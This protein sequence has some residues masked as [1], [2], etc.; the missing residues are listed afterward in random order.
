[1]HVAE[2]DEPVGSMLLRFRSDGS[3]DPAFGSGGRVD[4]QGAAG[5]LPLVSVVVQPDG[6]IVA[7]GTAL[8]DRTG[9]SSFAL[10]RTTRAGQRDSTFG[11]NGIVTTKF[12]YGASA[13]AVK[14]DAGRLVVAGDDWPKSPG[15]QHFA[16]ARYTAATGAL[17]RTF[18]RGGKVTGPFPDSTSENLA[19]LGFDRRRGLVLGG[20]GFAARSFVFA[21][22]RYRSRPRAGQ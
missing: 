22:A 15:P 5:F 16:A 12:G 3:L 9:G 10:L 8:N 13:R 18:G 20:E 1:V 17:D 19:A 14:W 4:A 6:R 11:R 21:L 7:A 2:T